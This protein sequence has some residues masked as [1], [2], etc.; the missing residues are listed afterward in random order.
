MAYRF[1]N[2]EKWDDA[3]FSELKPAN[4][5]LYLYLCDKCDIAGFLE[6]N[7]KK[8]AFDLGLCKQDVEGGLKSLECKFV[9]SADNK[10]IF[11]RNFLK[12]QK[13]YPLNDKSTTYKKIIECLE[14]KLQSFNYQEKED[15]FNTI[16]MG[17]Q[18]PIGISNSI[19]STGKGGMG[20]KGGEEKGERKKDDVK[21]KFAEFVSMT[22]AEYQALVTKLGN[23]YAAKRCIEILDNYKGSNGKKYK[24][25]YRA[26]L[27]WVIERYLKEKNDNDN[28][29][30]KKVAYIDLD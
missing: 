7:T 16:P 23:E 20:E 18:Y 1:T 9:Y 8:I 28:E 6:V 27:N 30:G 2:T 15:F 5:L 26:I 22:N 21:I 3:W 4:K 24:S 13:N 14:N 17:H 10:Y 11:I 25:D 19:G 29:T 12:H